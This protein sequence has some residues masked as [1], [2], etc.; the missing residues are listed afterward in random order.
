MQKSFCSCQLQRGQ[1]IPST[2]LHLEIACSYTSRMRLRPSNG[3]LNS[4]RCNYAYHSSA[5]AKSHS[6]LYMR[7][8]RVYVHCRYDGAVRLADTPLHRTARARCLSALGRLHDALLD[9]QTAL[10]GEPEVR[11]MSMNGSKCNHKAAA[12]CMMRRP[13]EE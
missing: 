11:R 3:A 5:V 2:P 1:I 10:Q 4:S 6:I 12:R 9:V 13:H 8:T 7:A